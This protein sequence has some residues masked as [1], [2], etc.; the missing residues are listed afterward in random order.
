MRTPSV[1]VIVDIGLSVASIERFWQLALTISK[2]IAANGRAWRVFP[3]SFAGRP[4]PPSRFGF[5]EV[6]IWQTMFCPDKAYSI[7]E[8][9]G[10]A[11]AF[12]FGK[13]HNF[14]FLRIRNI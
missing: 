7:G 3:Q 1:A 13:L 6:T 11:H 4:S 9:L 10:I 12:I 2:V 5:G 8:C 14:A